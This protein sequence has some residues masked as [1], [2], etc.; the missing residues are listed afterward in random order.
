MRSVALAKQNLWSILWRD[1]MYRR[2]KSQAT[3]QL[4]KE[5]SIYDFRVARV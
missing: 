5:E 3:K 1:F 4:L 2:E